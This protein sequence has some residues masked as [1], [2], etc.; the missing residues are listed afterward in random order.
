ML[1]R[2]LAAWLLLAS[3]CFGQSQQLQDWMY[4]CAVKVHAADGAGSGVLLDIGGVRYVAT[5]AHVAGMVQRARLTF[6]NG[7]V[8]AG[9]VVAVDR[10]MDVCVIV[11]ESEIKYGAKLG[12]FDAKGQYYSAGFGGRG[13]PYG[14]LHFHIGRVTRVSG[15]GNGR[16][17]WT[18]VGCRICPG[19]S[20]SGVY[21]EAG[22]VVGVF[23][24]CD[25]NTS[26]GTFGAPFAEVF[27]KLAYKEQ[28]YGG[29]C[30]PGGCPTCPQYQPPIVQGPADGIIY[31]Q[32][33]PEQPGADSPIQPAPV[34][35]DS[36]IQ[37]EPQ[38]D[39]DQWVSISERV[40]AIDKRLT[41]IEKQGPTLGP[42]G[43]QGPQGE[44]GDPGPAGKDATPVDLEALA[45]EVAKRLP[46]IHVTHEDRST[47]KVSEKDVY[48]GGDLKIW[49]DAKPPVAAR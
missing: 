33:R 30:G 12:C 28:Q 31:Y 16:W 35:D 26:I 24:G 5:N 36:P 19:D 8:C 45:A 23:W 13:Q 17:S 1:R 21:N 4:L 3:V 48:L 2:V 42:P 22:E 44:K 10:K 11:P 41:E 39:S 15:L 9:R 34:P 27:N 43:P 25:H 46:P 40:D 14:R 29:V 38:P 37:Q 6:C 32:P 47:G 7:H 20:G 18:E 49:L